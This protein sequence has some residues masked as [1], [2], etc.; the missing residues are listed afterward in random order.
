[1]N[2]ILWLQPALGAEVASARAGVVVQL[3]VPAASAL[4]TVTTTFKGAS[5]P[6]R[7]EPPMVAAGAGWGGAASNT[8]GQSA[9][10][11]AASRPTQ[12]LAAPTP[13]ALAGPSST[14]MAR[15]P[16]LAEV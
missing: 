4:G 12:L 7:A 16:S 2:P 3:A 10:V 11:K 15:S 13:A 1:A 5:A 8:A 6:A 14:S 9:L